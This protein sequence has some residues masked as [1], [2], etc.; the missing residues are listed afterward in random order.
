MN[1]IF[2]F[3]CVFLLSLLHLSIGQN[4][5]GFVFDGT[6]PV[7]KGAD[8]LSNPWAGGLYAPQFA[9]FDIDGDGQEDLFVFDRY[10]GR[11]LPF[12]KTS[13][14]ASF[15]WTYEQ[16]YAKLFPIMDDYVYLI[17]YNCDGKKDIFT[18]VNN[19]LGVY[20]N[21]GSATALQWQY[22]LP[23]GGPVLSRY[24]NNTY[25]N[26]LQVPNSDRPII[27]DLN[28]DGAI[29]IVTFGVFGSSLEFH[30][31]EVPCGLDFTRTHECWGRFAEG[32]F[33]NTIFLNA[34]LPTV[35]KRD[36]SE[37]TTNLI[38]HSNLGA[39]KT[40][41]AGATLLDLDLTNNGL[42]DILIGDI[43]SRNITAL[44]NTGTIDSAFISSK[45]SL[46][47]F[48]DTPIWMNLFPA[49]FYEDVDFD[50]VKD[51]IVAPNIVS[52]QVKNYNN[53]WMY[54]NLGQNSLPDF[55]RNDTAFLQSEMIDLGER[56]YPVLFD[57]NG[58]GLLDLFI[59]S[60]GKWVQDS[61]Y[62][63]RVSYYQNTGTVSN[64]EFSLVTENFANLSSFNLGA[65]PAPAFG[66]LNGDGLPD[67]LVGAESGDIHYFTNNGTASAPSFSLA[68]ANFG[69]INVGGFATPHLF[70]L[71]SNGT[72]D[73]FVGNIF[74]S[75]Y[76]YS[77][78]N[79][80]NP[81]FSF[82]TDRFGG[83]K[84][85]GQILAIGAS[86]PVFIKHN[87]NLSLFSG[88]FDQGVVQFDS[89]QQVVNSPL[90]VNAQIGNG[91][92]VT[93]NFNETPFGTTR[94]SGR[95][96]FLIR[97]AEMKAEG[98]QYGKIRAIHFQI[99]TSGNPTFQNGI[100]IRIGHTQDNEL[101]AF[102]N[103]LET[104]YNARTT[105]TQ[106]WNRIE[107]HKEFDWN[108]LDNL[109]FEV[110]FERNLPGNDIMV[111]LTDVGWPSHAYGDMTNFN[112]MTARGCEM[113]FQTSITK[114]PNVRLELLPSFKQVD[115]FL[116]DGNYNYVAIG[117]LNN[118]QYPD[119]II[120]TNSGGVQLFMGAEFVN[121]ISTNDFQPKK[122]NPLFQVYPNPTTGRVQLEFL[123]E[124]AGDAQLKIT[125]IS[126]AQVYMQPWSSSQVDL[127]LSDLPNGV[128]VVHLIHNN[129][130]H[131]QKLIIQR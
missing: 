69:G 103:N 48:Y 50:G 97:A 28:G 93:A 67:M 27:R 64:P 109:V 105:F 81:S 13:N 38:D 1:R 96:Q 36:P 108:E 83:I 86:N 70:D 55:E 79:P 37:I 106:G 22:A 43:D 29:D 74:G 26:N 124:F 7:Y 90:V 8:T 130:V 88:S 47:P 44:Y 72:L 100:T 76:H 68:S 95:N 87:G 42:P 114:R 128:Y 14:G 91:S 45:D 73:L 54:K 111:N 19:G 125:A 122:A 80:T 61:V 53:T 60:F 62:Q 98:M 25:R 115:G 129:E 34:C 24:N 5:F 121:T 31:G 92:L 17:D 41:H 101:T 30:A 21:T 71:D 59:S 63:A 89:I 102:H 33:D 77:N 56:A 23:N 46:F 58:D 104:V 2:I 99:T 119:I 82:V 117:N 52:P 113:P 110:C 118:D 78:T 10:G 75:I 126:G 66:D 15:R 65:M 11:K 16:Q 35:T 39:N 6:V 18:S 84:L 9:K 12:I 49:T 4:R 123:R 131:H 51:L 112:T 85:I 20:T 127:D 57:I 3:W 116:K 107:L 40:E 32:L 94:R 120:G